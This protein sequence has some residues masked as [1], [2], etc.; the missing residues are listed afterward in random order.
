MPLQSYSRDN[1]NPRDPARGQLQHGY[2]VSD[3]HEIDVRRHHGSAQPLFL[4]RLLQPLAA[5]KATYERFGYQLAVIEARP[6]WEKIMLAPPGSAGAAQVEGIHDLAV[7]MADAI[8]RRVVLRQS[9]DLLSGDRR[10]GRQRQVDPTGRPI[11]ERQ[12]QIDEV[13]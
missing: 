5:A 1:G 4:Q 10:R 9:L 8:S 6:P 13:G 12:G 2:L 11:G 7:S 3:G